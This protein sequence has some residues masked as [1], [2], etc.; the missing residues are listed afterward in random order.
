M[1]RVLYCKA[2][3]GGHISCSFEYNLSIAYLQGFDRQHRNTELYS[4][5]QKSNWNGKDKNEAHVRQQNVFLT[6]TSWCWAGPS[7]AKA[8]AT[9]LLKL[10]LMYKCIFD[11]YL[12]VA[13]NFCVRSSAELS[14]SVGLKLVEVNHSYLKR[15]FLL[16]NY[17]YFLCLGTIWQFL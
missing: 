15:N 3:T 10:M 4:F 7:L 12:W 1:S 14:I 11:S 16:P 8:G 5:Q 9:V 6:K 17:Y 2:S 13:S